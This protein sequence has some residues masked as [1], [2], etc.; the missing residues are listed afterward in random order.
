[1]PVYEYKCPKCAK[2]FDIMHAMDE[3]PKPAC[4]E[5]V[6]PLK[7]VYRLAGIAFK[8]GGWGHSN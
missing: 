7:R 4:T 3:Q 8:G 6:V 1:M 5:C 2:V